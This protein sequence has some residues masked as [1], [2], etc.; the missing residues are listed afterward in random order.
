MNAI[1]DVNDAVSIARELGMNMA[2]VKLQKSVVSQAGKH[3]ASVIFLHGSGA[4]KRFK[5]SSCRRGVP[6]EK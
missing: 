5:P 3:T 6:T 1:C 2:A 4:F